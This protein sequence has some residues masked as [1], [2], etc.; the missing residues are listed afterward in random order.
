MVQVKDEL[1]AL[2]G[3]LIQTQGWEVGIK[4]FLK[5]QIA[6]SPEEPMRNVI[7]DNMASVKCLRGHFWWGGNGVYL[8]R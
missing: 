7:Y 8:L 1:N 6:F 5:W 4:G 3:H 2:W